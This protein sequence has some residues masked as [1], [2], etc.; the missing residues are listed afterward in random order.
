MNTM[1]NEKRF[2]NFRRPRA[3][4]LIGIVFLVS[5]TAWC[6]DAATYH[7]NRDVRPILA[8]YCFACHGPDSASRKADLRLDRREDAI[9]QGALVP[10]NVA[11]SELIARIMT[12]DRDLVMPPAET[13]KTL[14][15]EQKEILRV[16]VA[17]GAEYERH[18]SLIP[19][20]LP[21][22][23]DVIHTDWVRTPIDRF[24]LARLEASGLEPA[25]DADP[26]VLFRRLHLDITG[27]PPRPHDVDAFVR[28]YG[29]DPETALSDWIDQ[30]MNLPAWGEHRAR[31]WLDAARYGDTHGLHFDNYREIWPYRDWV[32]R[33]F[34]ANQPFDQFIVEQIGGDL[35]PDPTD[36]QLIATGFQRC[37]IT[38]NEGGTIDEENLALYATDRVQTFGWVFLGMTTNCGQCHDHKFDPFTM[39]DFYS[40]A[41]FFRN[42]TQPAKDGNAK[43]GRGPVLVVP[44][45]EDRPR[46]KALPAEIAAAA[47]A[48]DARRRSAEPEF[49]SWLAQ[50]TPDVLRDDVPDDGLVVHLALNEGQHVPATNSCAPQD[51]VRTTGDVVW[52]PDG[53]FG[54]APVMKRNSTFELGPHGDFEKD[55][56]FSFG[57]WIRTGHGDVSGAIIARMD[58][59]RAYRGWDLWQQGRHL[60]VHLIDSWPGNALKAVTKKPVLQPGRWQHVLATWDGSGRIDGIRIYVDGVA[61]ELKPEKNTLQADASVRTETPLRIGQRSDAQEFRDGAVQDVRIYRRCLDAG[62]V[63]RLADVGVVKTILATAEEQR[64]EE[65]RNRLYD[66]YLET[67]DEQYPALAA[68]VDRLTA[69]QEAIQSRSPVTLIQQERPDTPPTAHILIR[70]EYDRPGEKVS[71]ATPEALHP[72]KDD[73]PRNRLGL[74]LWLIDPDNPLT[75]RVTVNRFWQEIFGRGIVATPED[76][77]VVGADP[78]HPDLLDW[79]AVDFQTS[80]WDV[81]RFFKQV[82]MSRTYR[83]SAAASPEK[84]QRDP[85]NVLLS[86]GPRFRMDAEMVRDYALAASGLLSPRMFGPGVKPYQPDGIWDVVGL[87]E[88]NTRVYV[89]DTGENLYRRSVYTF[90]KRMAPPPN[91][92]A[93]NAPSRE[94]CTVRRERTNTPLQALVTLNDPQFVEAARCLA[95]TALQAADRRGS[96]MDFIAQRVLCRTLKTEER[97]I[98]SADLKEYLRYY[99]THPDDAQALLATGES[100]RPEDM[101]SAELAAWTMVCSEVLNLDE[102]L[103][104]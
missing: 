15:A 52:V 4:T 46:W 62:E 86:R 68:A 84:R 49:R 33:M 18:W 26:R 73:L 36:D 81:R 59:P 60:A 77:G 55:Q 98:L 79:L 70:G 71:A 67:R 9:E 91:L 37:N 13:Q 16:W 29:D 104:K 22:L 20:T 90:W 61:V 69:E 5:G 35:L 100:P 94:V 80:G 97:A 17:E 64:S 82:L 56:P 31:Y 50:A 6:E 51:P 87:P 92:E 3:L 75:A 28:D 93:F 103:N 99:Q 27:L 58:E 88:G 38:T 41:A 83:Q 30:L 47:A 42:T 25:S 72:M 76:F 102:T 1:T 39:K 10:G 21:D 43:D 95:Q 45:A 63:K 7:Y 54:P 66:Y 44:S 85:D 12:D 32:I 101:P 40:L 48:R 53:P 8:E 78:S 19:P 65:Q 89:Q 96:R 74:G 2:C 34:N 23:P 24:V 11:D 14:S 57:A